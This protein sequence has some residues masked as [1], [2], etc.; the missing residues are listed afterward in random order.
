MWKPFWDN[1]FKNDTKVLSKEINIDK[2]FIEEH[3]IG[4]EP[5]QTVKD[6]IVKKPAL[7][8]KQ[9]KKKIIKYDDD[10]FLIP[11]SDRF[12]SKII[13]NWKKFQNVTF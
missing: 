1:L 11:D 13:N 2:D 4:N 10:L 5:S 9:L 8:M 12:E 3:L 7:R 6:M